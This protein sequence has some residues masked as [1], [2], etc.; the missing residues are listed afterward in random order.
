MPLLELAGAKAQ[1]NK[2]STADDAE[3]AVFIA[4]AVD[5]VEGVVGVVDP[6]PVTQTLTGRGPWILDVLPVLAVTGITRDGLALPV[7][8][9]DVQAGVL[10]PGFAG[11]GPL[12]L[13]YTAGRSP[14]PGALQLAARIIL[15][16]LW[17]TQR[18]T[19]AKSRAASDDDAGAVAG[20]GFAVPY[21]A[22][23]LM[24]PY[25]LPPAVA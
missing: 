1:L 11:W 14:V 8:D 24:R 21:R 9:V 7:S 18:G 4:A 20:V 15:E 12:L 22:A 13:T 2:T 25:T 6:R 17:R 3:L 10:H 23:D 5:L 19:S 16:H